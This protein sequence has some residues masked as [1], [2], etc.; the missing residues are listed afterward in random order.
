MEYLQAQ[1]YSNNQ[2]IT[3]LG[4]DILGF[5]E[6]S[7]ENREIF[8]RNINKPFGILPLKT[9]KWMRKVYADEET[10]EEN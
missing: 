10:K 6:K 2:Y 7:E 5:V 4:S 8:L 1:I 9:L 3:N